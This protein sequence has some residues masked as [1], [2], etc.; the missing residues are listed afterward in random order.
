MD[1]GNQRDVER[2]TKSAKVRVDKLKAALRFITG[3]ER[4]RFYLAELVR[5]TRAL[6]RVKGINPNDV[7]FLDGVKSV[8]FKVLNDVR[9]LDDLKPFGLL[10]AAIFTKDGDD[11]GGSAA[12]E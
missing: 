4:G 11:H 6:E 10:L 9:A 3:D 2:R 12:D 1:L 5:E 8:G 7:M